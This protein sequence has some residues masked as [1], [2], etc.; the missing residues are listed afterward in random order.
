MPTNVNAYRCN[1]CKKYFESLEAAEACES[2]HLKNPRIGSIEYSNEARLQTT[3]NIILPKSV[4]IDFDYND[5][6]ILHAIYKYDFDCE[7][8]D[9]SIT[10][11]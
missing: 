8:S 4:V 9:F 11:K 3:H 5:K 10:K 1:Y 2:K 7:P 6:Y